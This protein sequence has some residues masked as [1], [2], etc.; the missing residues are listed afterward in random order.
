[1]A[2]SQPPN[3]GDTRKPQ[4]AQS[5]QQAQMPGSGPAPQQGGT[6]R[7]SDWASI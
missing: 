6:T 4:P 7:F 3:G 1:M 2:S 5:Q